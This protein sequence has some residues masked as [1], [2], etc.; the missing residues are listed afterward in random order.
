MKNIVGVSFNNSENFEY[1]YVKDIEVKKEDFVIVENN[2]I[3][4]YGQVV[5]DIHPLDSKKLNKDLGNI[6]KVANKKDYN[7]NLDNL[8]QASF[9]LKKCRQ[10]VKKYNLQMNILDAVYTF[11]QEQLVFTFYADTR[12]DFRDLAK[13][14]ASIYKTRI[15]LYQ[16]GVR[17][18]AK[19]IGG[20]GLCGQKLCC[21][22]FIDEFDSVSISMAKNQN[23]SLN[24]TKINGVCG[25]LLCC[26][27][28]EDDCYK[29]CRKTLP[30]VGQTIETEHGT[31][32]VISLDV[33]KRTYKIE[34]K[35]KGIIEINGNN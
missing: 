24:P 1:Y 12:I 35:D 11:N 25:R 6:V 14:L 9:A 17:D 33:L 22:R 26:L 18:K 19:K 5:T 2:G 3:N 10:L 16:I 27:K 29:E 34:T 13:E 23:I 32:K 8:K 21:S 30:Q 7:K 28:Y 31:G 15:E 4:R 20:I